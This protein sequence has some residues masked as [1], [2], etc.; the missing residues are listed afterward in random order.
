VPRFDEL[1]DRTLPSTFTVL[2]LA[3]SGDGSLRQAVLD[4]NADAGPAQIT[5]APGLQ[6]MI[7]LTSGP[8]SITSDVTVSGPGAD[9]IAVSGNDAS[10][11]FSISGAT[12]QVA[13]D[14]LTITNG[15]AT[16]VTFT[17][18]TSGNTLTAGGG[19][20]N[21]GADLILSQVI[22]MDNQAV[23]TG[24]KS[25]GGGGAIEN[26]NGASLTVADST[27]SGNS[28]TS[29][30]FAGGGAIRN[31]V[32]STALIEGSTFTGNQ[33]MASL[34]CAGGAIGDFAGSQLTVSDSTFESNLARGADGGPGSVGA[35]GDGGAPLPW[36]V[37]A[38]SKVALLRPRSLPV[39]SSATR[40]MEAPGATAGMA[41]PAVPVG[42]PSGA[43][44]STSNRPS[45]S[46][47]ATSPAM[48]PRAVLAATAER[49]A[50][51]AAR[52][53]RSVA[54]SLPRLVETFRIGRPPTSTKA[55][56]SATERWA[57]MA[58][59]AAA[60]AMAASGAKAPGAP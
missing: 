32:N 55:N 35:E 6:G 59:R 47:P 17:D 44:V 10:R 51:V 36:R 26:A 19:I 53:S 4:A 27:F 16:D 8:L 22:L 13:I 1:E 29:E 39:P 7:V 2:N 60:A 3:D 34:L 49:V 25:W 15:L 40:P 54:P 30:S 31:D 56:S 45:P 21:D 43:R 14:D 5:F 28:A 57:A 58:A 41:R 52:A 12:T 46:A 11:V 20:L 9:Q 23:A 37:S 38:S 33:I 18:A 48:A 50:T 24:L 42:I